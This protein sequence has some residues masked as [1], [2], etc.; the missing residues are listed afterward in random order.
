M[1]SVWREEPIQLSYGVKD[2]S[3]RAIGFSG[4]RSKP[5]KAEGVNPDNF[6]YQYLTRRRA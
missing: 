2:G 6:L 1:S 4:Q 3:D 5:K